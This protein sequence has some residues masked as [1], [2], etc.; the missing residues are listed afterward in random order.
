MAK[1]ATI[2]VPNEGEEGHL[3][4]SSSGKGEIR[5]DKLA[6]VVKQKKG[7]RCWLLKRRRMGLQMKSMSLG[8]RRRML[9]LAKKN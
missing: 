4:D 8:W 7:G 2:E 6:N 9:T 5:S 1:K 3:D